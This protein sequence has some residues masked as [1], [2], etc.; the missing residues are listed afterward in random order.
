MTDNST[1]SL[2]CA[3]CKQLFPATSMSEMWQ[4]PFFVVKLF[5]H[6]PPDNRLF[7]RRCALRLNALVI[8]AIVALFAVVTCRYWIHY[9]DDLFKWVA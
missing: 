8:L 2:P 6:I 5:L 4:A 3:R 1:G 7:C 9:L